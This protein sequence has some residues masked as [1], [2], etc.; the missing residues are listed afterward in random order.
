[1]ERAADIND[2]VLKEVVRKAQIG[3]TEM[4]VA[5]LC[6]GPR[7]RHQCRHRLRHGCHVRA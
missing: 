4:Q 7:P 3:M 5:G 1:M 6:R 2:V